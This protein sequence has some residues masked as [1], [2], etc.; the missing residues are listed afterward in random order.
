VIHHFQSRAGDYIY[1]MHVNILLIVEM[2]GS[3][4]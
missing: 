3:Y 4:I 2:D 1:E